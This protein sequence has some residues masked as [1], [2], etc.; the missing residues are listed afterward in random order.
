MLWLWSIKLLLP[1]PGACF[2]TWIHGIDLPLFVRV[3][4]LA[5]GQSYDCPSA[6]EATLLD[7]SKINLQQIL[8]MFIRVTPPALVPMPVMQP[9]SIRVNQP[10]IKHMNRSHISWHVLLYKLVPVVPGFHQ[11]WGG[12]YYTV[13]F[14]VSRWRGYQLQRCPQWTNL[15]SCISGVPY[16]GSH[17]TGIR[18]ALPAC[19][20]IVKKLCF[21]WMGFRD[22]PTVWPLCAFFSILPQFYVPF[23]VRKKNYNCMCLLEFECAKRLKPRSR[24]IPGGFDLWISTYGL[25]WILTFSIRQNADIFSLVA[26]AL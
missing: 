19:L 16:W 13:A 7:M 5:L 24:A 10:A 2:M 14:A 11:A 18:L 23:Y 20:W 22:S 9:W 21:I 4:S 8:P 17:L 25:W 1:R 6:S 3:A 15:I 12:C 26:T